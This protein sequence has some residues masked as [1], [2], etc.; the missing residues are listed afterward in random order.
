MNPST[1]HNIEH[2]SEGVK[3]TQEHNEEIERLKGEKF[4]VF[5]ILRLET[6]ENRTHS[7][8]IAELLN[9]QGSHLKKKVFLDSFLSVAGIQGFDTTRSG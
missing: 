1:Y 7:V 2:L 5:S 4:N 6:S 9:P 8:F 3:K